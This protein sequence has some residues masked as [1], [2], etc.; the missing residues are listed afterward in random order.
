MDLTHCTYVHSIYFGANHNANS[1]SRVWVSSKLPSLPSLFSISYPLFVLSVWKSLAQHQAFMQDAAH[2]DLG[3]S[4]MDAMV[5]PNKIHQALVNNPLSTLE[6]ALRAPITQF[7]YITMRP[8]HDRSYELEPLIEKLQAK[9]RKIPACIASCWGPSV[10]KEKMMVGILGWTNLE[11]SI[12][13]FCSMG[14]LTYPCR[15]KMWLSTDL[16]PLL[17]RESGN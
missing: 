13:I 11:V 2:V 6:K 1:D 14:C 4:L 17:F 16:C 10:E 7:I 12:H 15:L 9:L 3:L 5:G 8:L